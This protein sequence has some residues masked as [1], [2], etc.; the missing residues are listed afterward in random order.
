MKNR[1][2]RLLSGADRMRRR[3]GLDRNPVRR[4]EDHIQTM[5]TWSLLL[6]FLVAA[7]MTPYSV[8]SH[9]YRTGQRIEHS[10]SMSLRQVTAAIVLSTS[11]L[12]ITWKDPDGTSHQAAYPVG[13][14][15]RG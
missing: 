15:S 10:Q 8:G 3:A 2:R 13:T 9:V 6:I 7:T 5:I 11:G 1:T 4:R 12:Q 14:T